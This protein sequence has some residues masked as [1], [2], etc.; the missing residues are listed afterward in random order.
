VC[1]SLKNEY[2]EQIEY[3][4]IKIEEANNERLQLLK[5]FNEQLEENI[6]QRVETYKSKMMN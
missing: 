5:L 1:V 2:K 6:N 3:M 4:K